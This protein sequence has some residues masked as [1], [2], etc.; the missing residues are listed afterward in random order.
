MKDKKPFYI[1]TTLPYVNADPHIGFALEIIQADALARYRRLTGDDVFFNTGTD[2]HGQKIFDVAKEAGRDVQEY[3]DYY[4]AEFRKLKKILNLSNDTFIRTTDSAH[5]LAAQE[6]WKRC[7]KNGDIYL[8][9]YEG[10]YCVGCEYFKAERD[11]ENGKCMLHPNLE[12]Q[13]IKEENYFFKFKNYEEKLLKQLSEPGSVIPDW[14]REEAINFVKAG[15]EDFSVS[16]EKKRLSWGIPVPG[17]E[18]QVMYVWFDALTNYISTLGWPDDKDGNFKKFW[19]NGETLQVAGKDQVRFQS[20]M[21][22]AMLM[23]ADIKTTDR[24]FYHGFI[25]SGGQKMS[26]SL[27][28]VVSPLDIIGLFEGVTDFPEDVLRFV[29]LHDVPSFEDGDVTIESIKTSYAGNL[30]NGLGNLVSRIMKMAETYLDTPV[31]IGERDA[32]ETV[33]ISM[34][35]FNIKEA[36]DFIWKEISKLDEIIQK[37]EP[38]KVVKEDKEKG[39]KIISGLVKNLFGVALDLEPFLP[40]TSLEIQKLIKENKMPEKPLFARLS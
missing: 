17:D 39:V 29:V 32:N 1:T 22:Q 33:E 14:R 15:L 25:N 36:V 27:G 11:L 16:R 4:A 12:L 13:K 38:F 31:N 10:L 24:I 3:T 28:N 2:E 37:E 26:K 30:S 35:K 8:K 19:D 20:L 40:R 6:M 5:H 18:N 9:E 21:W 23:S 34:D 7:E